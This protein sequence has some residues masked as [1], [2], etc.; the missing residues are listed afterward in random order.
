MPWGLL[1]AS[2]TVLLTLGVI[3]YLS[4]SPADVPGAASVG[5]WPVVRFRVDGDGG[6]SVLPA[7]APALET[8]LGSVLARKR[9]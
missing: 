1:A 2:A 3:A 7:D 4:E 8:F 9:R 5:N 6:A